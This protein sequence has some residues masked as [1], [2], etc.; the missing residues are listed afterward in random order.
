MNNKKKK[1]KI[2]IVDDEPDLLTVMGAT[3]TFGGFDVVKALSGKEAILLADAEHPDLILLDIRMPGMDGV[4]TTDIL[5]S[6]DSTRN[7]PIV[8]LSN[9]V[10]DKQ[11]V[12]GHVLGSKIGDLFFI[13]K[14]YSAEK[15]IEIVHEALR[16][17]ND[18]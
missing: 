18:K 13:P 10:E 3:L 8:Y 4:K 2:L 5:R 15:I 9:L 11:V 6:R 7:I 16:A 17:A 1:K 14:T 12:A